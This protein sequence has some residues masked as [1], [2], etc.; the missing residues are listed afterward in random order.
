M[1]TKKGI[2]VAVLL[3][4]SSMSF[5]VSAAN[6]DD[7]ASVVSVQD[8]LTVVNQPTQNCE[9]V[10]VQNQGGSGSNIASSIIGGTVGALLG[11]TIGNGNGRIAATA[12]GAI[13]G[14][15]VGN[16]LG[17]SNQSQ[18]TQ[19]H[20]TTV[21]NQVNGRNG[22]L[23]EYIYAGRHFSTVT[24]NAPGETIRVAVAVTPR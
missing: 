16:N 18:T 14:T 15:V 6:Y 5:S 22:Y 13:A 12:G 2:S 23:V 7:V 4:L 19:R 1:N 24:Q 21:M 8:N 9:D 17:G 10:L 3:A 11:R 20:C